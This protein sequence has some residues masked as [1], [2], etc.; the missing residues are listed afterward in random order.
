MAVLALRV[1]GM[2]C[3]HCERR[4]RQAVRGLSGVRSVEVDLGEKKVTVDYEEG[5]VDAAAI[6]EAIRR[7][8]YEAEEG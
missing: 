4:I 8:G 2:S 1:P 5:A 7:A 6:K 3:G